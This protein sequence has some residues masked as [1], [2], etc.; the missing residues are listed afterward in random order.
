MNALDLVEQTIDISR[1]KEVRFRLERSGEEESITLASL[2]Y[3][4]L[5]FLTNI[6]MHHPQ[7]HGDEILNVWMNVKGEMFGITLED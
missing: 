5:A 3:R 4:L 6:C 7:Y 2:C 1:A